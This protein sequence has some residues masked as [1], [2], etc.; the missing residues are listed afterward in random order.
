[1][2]PAT[3]KGELVLM[4]FTQALLDALKLAYASGTTRVTY[5]GKTVEYASAKDLMQ[6]ISF[7][8]R[9]LNPHSAKAARPSAGF[10]RFRRGD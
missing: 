7:I 5:E 1:M 8:E 6:R 3:E 4:A 10:V 2:D 9:E